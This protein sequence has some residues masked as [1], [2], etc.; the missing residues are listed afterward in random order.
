MI[1][2]VAIWVPD[3]N[4]VLYYHCHTSRVVEFCLL[5]EYSG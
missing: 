5:S 3:A 1:D 2:K 4:I